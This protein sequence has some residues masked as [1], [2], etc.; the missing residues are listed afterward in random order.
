[1]LPVLA[2]AVREIEL[3]VERGRVR[4]ATRVTF[5]AVALLVR[6]ERSRVKTAV[7]GESQRA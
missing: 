6:E 2:K 1:M 5:Q 3:A 7:I 4:P